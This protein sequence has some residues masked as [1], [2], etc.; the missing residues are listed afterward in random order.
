MI[1]SEGSLASEI[2]KILEEL[3]FRTT[4]G[5]HDF[6]YDWKKNE[7]PQTEVQSFIDKVQDQLKGKNVKFNITTLE[8]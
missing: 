5:S 3:G 1:S 4:M 7:V 8:Y 6:S 2:T